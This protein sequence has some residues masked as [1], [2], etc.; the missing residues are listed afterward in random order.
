M[1]VEF[2][3]KWLITCMFV[4]LTNEV[5]VNYLKYVWTNKSNSL[6]HFYYCNF[7]H[8][9]LNSKTYVYCDSE[10][11]TL[12]IFIWMNKDLQLNTWNDV[13]YWCILFCI[14]I[15]FRAG[16]P[17]WPKKGFRIDSIWRYINS[18]ILKCTSQ[19]FISMYVCGVVS[20]CHNQE[21]DWG[22]QLFVVALNPEIVTHEYFA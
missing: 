16:N 13:E 3:G 7:N 22:R 14:S 12:N 6:D 9:T 20:K 11:F 4:F 2:D 15:L 19:F 17:T 5:C 18:V 21:S 1:L 8:C 10:W